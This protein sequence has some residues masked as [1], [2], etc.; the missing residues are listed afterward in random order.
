VDT[1]EATLYANVMQEIKG[2]IEIIRLFLSGQIH[3]IHK[4][5]TTESIGLQF[6]KVFELISFASLTANKQQYSEAYNDF[7]KH[8]EAAKLLKN[9]DYINSDFYP[10]PVV[11]T[12]PTIPGTKFNFDDREHDYLT[13]DDLVEAHGRCGALLHGANPYAKPIDY[14][15][16]EKQFPLWLDKTMNL[17]NTH[18]IR[19]E[20]EDEFH[21]CFMQVPAD[22]KV[23]VYKAGPAVKPHA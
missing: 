22:D 5:I 18:V 13:R 9:L 1:T 8:W 7:A 23:H 16:Y 15:F 4:P 2:R 17:L 21:L 3:A 6:R 12:P 10:H 11:Q 20:G 14:E 19:L